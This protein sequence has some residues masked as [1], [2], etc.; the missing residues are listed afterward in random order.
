MG[1]ARAR[2]D[3]FSAARCLGACAAAGRAGAAGRRAAPRES[4]VSGSAA[5]AA[6]TAAVV[7]RAEQQQ[8]PVVLLRAARHG[9]LDSLSLSLSLS[10]T[11]NFY[12]LGRLERRRDRCPFEGVSRLSPRHRFR[13]VRRKVRLHHGR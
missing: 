9:T 12:G 3:S 2:D 5:T 6:A 13:V 10:L 4:S 7:E 8:R 11:G 1:G